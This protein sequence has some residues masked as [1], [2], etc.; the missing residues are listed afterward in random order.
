MKRVLSLLLAFAS[1]FALVSCTD[2]KQTRT[3]FSLDTYCT[4][5]V[6]GGDAGALDAAEECLLRY[7]ALW[8]ATDPESAVSRLNEGSDKTPDAET[9]HLLQIAE[10]VR[11]ESDGAFDVRIGALVDAYGYYTDTYRVPSEAS[12]AAFCAALDDAP[13]L[14]GETL[15]LSEGQRLDLGGIAKGRIADLCA[16]ALKSRG[17]T[18]AVLSFGGNVSVFG[19]KPDGS[20]FSVAVSD[21]QD[22]SAYLGTLRL[23][24][25][26]VVTAGGYQRGFLENGVYYHHILDPKT[27]LP[28][29]SGLLS[30]TVLSA[31]GAR[32]DALSTAC[33]VL[34][35]EGALSLWRA[36]G[37]FDLLLVRE[38]GSIV[39]TEGLEGVFTAEEKSVEFVKKNA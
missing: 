12:R 9:Q 29:E 13:L 3:V 28:A 38:D 23:R 2:T 22:P 37:D 5:T 27:A 36:A 34:G 18:A 24:E 26:S 11:R 1:L 39:C 32:A 20:G 35:E 15:C 7:E 21:P 30:A 16:T 33:Y 31:D 19:E 6:W 25:G 17:V 4:V 10:E 8:S 14:E